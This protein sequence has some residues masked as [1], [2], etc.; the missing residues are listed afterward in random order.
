MADQ[1]VKAL[2]HYDWKPPGCV[3][4]GDK[5]QSYFFGIMCSLQLYCITREYV[6][7]RSKYGGDGMYPLTEMLLEGMETLLPSRMNNVCMCY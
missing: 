5:F 3:C 7:F 4:A 6:R 1:T 2:G